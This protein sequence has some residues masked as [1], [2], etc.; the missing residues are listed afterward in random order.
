MCAEDSGVAKDHVKILQYPGDVEICITVLLTLVYQK[1]LWSYGE[2][3][4]LDLRPVSIFPLSLC[5]VEYYNETC[6]FL[7]PL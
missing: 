3:S 6:F 1:D 4:E 5:K 2:G 7:K